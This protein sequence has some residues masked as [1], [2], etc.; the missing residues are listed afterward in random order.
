MMV[1]GMRDWEPPEGLCFVEQGLQGE[2][3]G[4]AAMVQEL[5]GQKW[6]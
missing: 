2:Q 5:M 3:L 4:D 1:W 6:M